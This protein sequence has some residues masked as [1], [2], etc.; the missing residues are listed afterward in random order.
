MIINAGSRLGP[1]EVV[2]RLGAG[3]MGEVWKAR[4]TRLDRSVAIKVLSSELAASPQFRSRFEREARSISQLNHPHICTLYD[5]GEDYLVMELLDGESLAD[6]LSRG[7]LPLADVLRYGAQIA[8]ALATAHRAGI[9]HRDLKPGN[10]MI[11]KGGAKLLDFGLAKAAQ[12]AVSLSDSEATAHRG[13][14]KPLTE[15]GTILGTFQYMAPEQLEGIEADARTDIFALGVLLYEMVTGKR[16]FEGKTRTS[17]IA[18][19]VG[20]HPRPLHEVQPLTP[21][22]LEHVIARCLEKDPADRWQ[23]A[24]DVA[25]ELR[26]AGTGT[27]KAPAVSARMG[28]ASWMAGTAVLI[29]IAL[30]L[31][32]TRRTR[33]E[34]HLVVSLPA[35][36]TPGT[37]F[38]DNVTLSPD[39]TMA[40]FVT[41]SGT[42]RS[43]W[44]RSIDSAE[45][46]Q[47]PATNGAS[48]PFWSPDGANVGFFADGKL[49][50]IAVAGGP[51]QIVCDAPQPFG[52][53]W[54]RQGMIV[55]AATGLGPLSK[56]S[57][58]GGTPRIF[59][60]LG[61]REESHR[62][63]VFLP[64]GEH[65]IFLGDAWR[66]EDHHLKV[67][68]LRG[69]DARDL[70]QAITNAIYVEPGTILYVRGGSLFAQDFD[71][72][73]LA[74]SGEPRVVAG[75]I[76]P[77][78]PNH[79]YEFSASGTGRLTYRSVSSAA[80]LA[81]VDRQGRTLEVVSE[82]RRIRAFQLSPDARSVVFEGID[83]E[84][85]SDDLWLLDFA[86]RITT[87]LTLDP[88]GDYAPV[89][90][91]D[92]RSIIFSS[93]R[94]GLGDPHLLDPANI[95]T[96]RQVA[97]TPQGSSP[98]SWSSKGDVVALELSQRVGTDVAIYSTRTNQVTPY[99]AT[100]F[101]ESGAAFS[102]DASRIAYT[103]D[104]SGR[105]EIYVEG[106]PTHA[107]RR[108]ISTS[109]GDNAAWSKA[110]NELYY[111]PPSRILMS[112]ELTSD[113]ASPKELFRL[114]GTF[115]Q[116][117]PDGQRFLVDQPVEDP[118]RIPVTLVT[119]W[120]AGLTQK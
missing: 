44:L 46:R 45:A 49:Q 8:D 55:F 69:D 11:T 88:A 94:S 10:I 85:R 84:G 5:V 57:A 101:N 77:N 22:A 91:P 97:H 63:P 3:G 117:S 75:E 41:Y 31:L 104:E 95:S 14:D 18:H 80:R 96:V 6:R 9:V 68:S 26:W 62:W 60:R 111:V 93:M 106:F 23:N 4:D 21:P 25:E 120:M 40:A 115:Y 36:R 82:P 105:S 66:A 110:G 1:Y 56:V 38:Y 64:D 61:P 50:R 42:Q 118:T 35:P 17:L 78:G 72:K 89:W 19:I 116:T 92:G 112:V 81:W 73:R 100:S 32:A 70:T 108:Q 76:F 13:S 109:G 20:G 27:G 47:L 65:F 99:L 33:P 37:E 34:P 15:K 59:T 86:R 67:A 51:P 74:L 39:G 24:H 79:H 29:A 12:Q 98:T 43:L 113:T 102:P 90:S 53:T 103:S 58:S 48:W 83:A 52:G 54:S 2:S 28:R 107:G 16:A 30:S 71:A 7:A 119:N 87:R 114:P